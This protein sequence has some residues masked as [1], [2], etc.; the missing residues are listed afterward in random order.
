ME[1]SSFKEQ[2]WTI[3]RL[4]L[5]IHKKVFTPFSEFL[6]WNNLHMYS[7]ASVVLVNEK[8]V[9]WLCESKLISILIIPTYVK[10]KFIQRNI[11]KGQPINL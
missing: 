10:I 3:I 7:T 9:C 11:W 1:M 6:N 2:A 5:W 8:Y 4:R